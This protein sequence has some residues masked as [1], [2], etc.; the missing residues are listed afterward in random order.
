MSYPGETLPKSDSERR[1][2]RHVLEQFALIP[3]AALAYFGVR[4]LTKGSESTA[5][6]IRKLIHR[7]R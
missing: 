1:G 5:D 7:I 3:A 2:A 4:G 6:E